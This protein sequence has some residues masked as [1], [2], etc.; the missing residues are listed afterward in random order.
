MIGKILYI[1]VLS[2]VLVLFGAANSYATDEDEINAKIQKLEEEVKALQQQLNDQRQASAQASTPPAPTPPKTQIS[3]N[4]SG[5]VAPVLPAEISSQPATQEFTKKEKEKDDQRG[6]TVTSP[7]GQ[8]SFT[9]RGYGQV[10]GRFPIDDKAGNDQ[11]EFLI[12]RAR[13]VFLG[14]SG[15]ASF[16]FMP[17]FAGST[18]KIYDLYADYHFYD[19]ANV[20]VGKDKPPIGLERLVNANEL[21]FIERGLPTNLVPN[22]DIGVQLFG[23]I[24]PELDYRVGIFNGAPDLG[25]VDSD[26]DGAKDVV[27]RL[28][29]NPFKKSNI[30]PLQGLGFGVAGSTGQHDGTSKNTELPAYLTVA[31]VQFFGY[32]SGVVADG[33]NW[34]IS[35]QG[36]YY[37]GPFGVLAE[38][39]SSTTD[40]SKGAAHADVDNHAWQV[41]TSYVLT[42]EKVDYH[43]VIPEENFNIHNGGWGAFEAVAR[44]GELKIDSNAFPLFADPTTSAREAKEWLGG[45]NWYLNYNLK[46][47]INYANTNFDGGA[48]GGGD[49]ETERTF[50]T[51]MQYKF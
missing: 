29:A 35:P 16:R 47:A 38:Y 2:A 5:Q 13:P 50:L 46:L 20:R 10:D 6:I 17:D 15:D 9:I 4:S 36:Y 30:E 31:Q 33:T 39:V 34:R 24:I 44:Y 19:Q 41:E 27:A 32:N 12:R 11:S 3:G 25:N 21:E 37:Y 28:F 7:D 49:R 26:T 48:A 22:R 14:T 23:N 45:L 43:G 1:G 18:P 8:N 42:G 40:V 51:R